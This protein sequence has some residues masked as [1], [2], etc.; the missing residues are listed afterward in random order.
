MPFEATIRKFI[1]RK[2][3]YTH[4]QKL[5]TQIKEFVSEQLCGAFLT[6]S[7]VWTRRAHLVHF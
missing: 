1:S 3:Q 5:Q 6:G 4:K 7:H 2:D